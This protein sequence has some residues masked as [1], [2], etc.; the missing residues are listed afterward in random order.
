MMMH[1]FSIRTLLL[2]TTVVAVGF[3]L[4]AYTHSSH[5]Y[6]AEIRADELRSINS[7]VGMFGPGQ[8]VVSEPG[9]TYAFDGSIMHLHGSGP[10]YARFYGRDAYRRVTGISFSGDVDPRVIDHFSHFSSLQWVSFSSPVT[11]DGQFSP[12][13]SD[14]LFAIMEFRQK[15]TAVSVSVT[16][17]DPVENVVFD[18]S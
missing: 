10:C 16:C 6:N 9:V 14:L 13:F 2:V 4:F 17:T 5:A 18:E 7:I 15:S 11:V 1:R 8:I 12:R 3:G